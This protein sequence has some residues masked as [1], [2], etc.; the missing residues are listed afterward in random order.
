MLLSSSSCSSLADLKDAGEDGA[1]LSID[2]DR[3]LLKVAERLESCDMGRP[4]GPVVAFVFKAASWIGFCLIGGDFSGAVCVCEREDGEAPLMPSKFGGRGISIEGFVFGLGGGVLV[5]CHAGGA[6][7]SGSG[8]S[9]KLRWG[10]GDLTGGGEF[11]ATAEGMAGG[12]VGVT[13]R[14]CSN[15]FTRELVGGIGVS[16]VGLSRGAVLGAAL[17]ADCEPTL[18][19]LLRGCW[20][21]DACWAGFCCSSLASTFPTLP[22]G[23]S[24]SRSFASRS[25]VI[26]GPRGWVAGRRG[27][28]RAAA[29]VAAVYAGEGARSTWV[30][31]TP[32]ELELLTCLGEGCGLLP[33]RELPPV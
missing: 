10:L 6:S 19:P 25:L 3:R 23:G 14:F 1:L 13:G 22:D 32:S 26:S 28:R 4:W 27:L 33:L 31:G 18:S 30:S 29:N 7:S 20:R 2:V 9:V 12:C 11:L 24:T 5:S 8:G 21:G 15:I 16:S 17:A